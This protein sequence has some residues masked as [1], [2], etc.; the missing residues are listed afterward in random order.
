MRWLGLLLIGWLAI[1]VAV[2]DPF[3][4]PDAAI[5]IRCGKTI[6]LDFNKISLAELIMLLAECRK[7][8]IVLS[9]ELPQ[10]IAIHLYQV[11]YQ[12]ALNSVLTAGRLQL[13][14]QGQVSYVLQLDQG[15][16]LPAA[17][18]MSKNLRLQYAQATVLEQQIKQ[19]GLLSAAG[20]II[21]DKRLNHLW[22]VD[23]AKHLQQITAFVQQLDLPPKHVAIQAYMLS[24]DTSHLQELGVEFGAL[25]AQS[26]SQ[27]LAAGLSNEIQIRL[28]HL[29]NGI[30][31]AARLTAIEQQGFGRILA[32]PHLLAAN[33]QPAEIESGEDIPYQETSLSGG[34]SVTFKKAVLGLNVTPAITPGNKILLKIKIS[35]DKV[36][37]LVVNG[38]PAIRTQEVTTQAFVGNGQTVLLGGIFTTSEERVHKRVP[39]LGSIPLIGKLFQHRQWQ[40]SERELIIFITPTVVSN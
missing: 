9:T 21:A 10:T 14:K 18:M 31:L 26:S 36:S 17:K 5:G 2:T 33:H 20:K 6:S 32:S 25:A 40:R 37:S 35:Q 28:A 34:T 11:S 13:K 4:S 24:I 39:L 7:Q 23:D 12:Q 22:V 38:M 27:Q 3:A 29:P 19:A 16:M 8:N 1:A 30:D 15:A